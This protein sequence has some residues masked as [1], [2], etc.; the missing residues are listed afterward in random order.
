MKAFC[1]LALLAVTSPAFAQGNAPTPN[2][3]AQDQKP[4]LYDSVMGTRCFFPPAPPAHAT[5]PVCGAPAAKG[6]VTEPK[7]APK[8]AT[9]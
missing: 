9:A 3:G 4:F 7:P 1:L 2:A 5:A 8:R 6:P